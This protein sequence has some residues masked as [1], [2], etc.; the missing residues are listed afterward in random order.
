MEKIIMSGKSKLTQEQQALVVERYNMGVDAQTLMKEFNIGLNAIQI[1]IYRA[2]VALRK[3]P[4]GIPRTS[5]EV[6]DAA[7][8]EYM[9]TRK[10]GAI[11]R[12]FNICKGTLYNILDRKG[13][14]TALPGAGKRTRKEFIP[15]NPIVTEQDAQI[16]ELHRMGKSKSDI[17]RMVN[18]SWP[19]V[20][21]AL[22]KQGLY[23]PRH[24]GKVVLEVRQRPQ[25]YKPKEKRYSVREDVFDVLT[26]EAFYYLGFLITDGCIHKAEM[27]PSYRLHIRI[28][29]KDERL[30]LD[31]RDWIGS[32]HKITYLMADTFDSGVPKPYCVFQVTANKMCERLIQ[33]HVAPAKTPTASAPPEALNSSDF[34]RGAVD[35]DGCVYDRADG[36]AYLSGTAEIVDQFEVYCQTLV[37]GLT[38]HKHHHISHCGVIGC[39]VG[40]IRHKHE[41]AII[42]K[43][44]YGNNPVRCL[45]RKRALATTH[46]L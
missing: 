15:K 43:T 25:T 1:A 11:C 7:A 16:A 38:L 36:T 9:K 17:A 40:R 24:A 19:G 39:W 42:L 2:G 4:S 3:K 27:R 18:M 37:P 34:W 30:L 8:A 41:A 35:G 32:N 23:A 29:Q 46:W 45:E 14:G 44:L 12:K 6:E 22:K 20:A 33:L 26:P 31:F 21:Y 10:T 5:P 28:S 13:I